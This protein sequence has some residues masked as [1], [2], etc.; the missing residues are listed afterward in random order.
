MEE[1]L[2]SIRKIISD[3]SEVESAAAPLPADAAKDTQSMIDDMFEEGAELEVV[4]AGRAAAPV[5][6][7]DAVL[8]LTEDMV[9]SRLELV[10]GIGDEVKFDDAEVAAAAPASDM[11]VP[12]TEAVHTREAA[13][14]AAGHE[15]ANGKLLSQQAE[16]AVSSAFSSLAGLM[17]S[18]NSRTLEDLVGDILRPMLKDWLDDNLPGLVEKI[19]RSEIERVTRGGR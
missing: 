18:N 1:I 9:A 17:L 11:P 16:E 13:P 8:E 12:E 5:A 4:D 3:D 19:V 6:A 15:E 7:D 10:E 2:A 14:A